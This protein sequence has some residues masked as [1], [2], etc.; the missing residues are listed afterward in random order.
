MLRL[1]ELLLFLGSIGAALAGYAFLVEPDR[2]EVVRVDIHLP[3]LKTAAT[4]GQLSDI[5]LGT[6]AA[7]ARAARAVQTLMSLS[8]DLIVLTG[9]FV[10]SRVG[11]ED[12]PVLAPLRAP[13]G[14][15][16]VLGNH[17]HWLDP[18][19]VEEA[20]GKLGIRV[21]RNEGVRLEVGGHPLWV[22]GLDDMWNELS[23]LK[24]ASRDIPAG[25]VRIA[26]V[27]EPD[28]AASLPP[29][30]VDLQLSG[31]THGGQVC[32]P[33]R[34]PL[35]LP[36]LGHRFPSGLQWSGPTA[37]YTNRGLGTIRP[38]VRFHCRPEITLL[39]LLPAP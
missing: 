4:V 33:G 9:D 37:V 16:A 25:D 31:H 21:L 34:G 2:L 29:G 3:R 18:A 15:Y 1:T 6:P 17:D 5:H 38:H 35:L 24:A 8:P 27:H 20:L 32:L 36:P 26:L 7:S 22:I 19:G 28:F 23:D 11:L 10:S 14:V 13:L 12:L 30:E 39:R